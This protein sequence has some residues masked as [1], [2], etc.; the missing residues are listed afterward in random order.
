MNFLSSPM[1][2]LNSPKSLHCKWFSLSE[3]SIIRYCTCRTA[4]QQQ[5]R[6]RFFHPP[7]QVASLSLWK[8]FVFQQ[9][10][11]PLSGEHHHPLGADEAPLP[12]LFAQTAHLSLAVRPTLGNAVQQHHTGQHRWGHQL[13]VH[14]ADVL[15][16]Q[17]CTAL[18]LDVPCSSAASGLSSNDIIHMLRSVVD[19]KAEEIRILAAA[20]LQR[21]RW[22]TENIP[23]SPESEARYRLK[24]RANLKLPHLKD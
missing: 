3:E 11:R 24:K 23:L 20:H 2:E 5:W 21:S 19:A 13:A 16:L 17:C 18:H 15:H 8:L 4:G 22:S 12:L 9:L 1:L 10:H 7:T 6:H 14:T